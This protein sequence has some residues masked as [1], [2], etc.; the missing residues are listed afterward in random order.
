VSWGAGGAR[1][2]CTEW[3]Q[4]TNPHA[5]WIVRDGLRKM[6]TARPMDATRILSLLLLHDRDDEMFTAHS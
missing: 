5:R 3:A 4:L 1:G 6:K 2:L